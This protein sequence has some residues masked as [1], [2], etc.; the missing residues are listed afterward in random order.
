MGQ[1]KRTEP[2][3]KPVGRRKPGP[4]SPDHKARFHFP[5]TPL[6]IPFLFPSTPISPRLSPPSVLPPSSR[7]QLGF[8][9]PALPP[10]RRPRPPCRS[11]EERPSRSSRPRSPRRTTTRMTWHTSRRRRMSK[12]P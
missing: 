3:I 6:Y 10:H 2:I 7:L 9:A 4:C 1:L 5:P 8:L 12:R 11:K